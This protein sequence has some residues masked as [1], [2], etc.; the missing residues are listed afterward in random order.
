MRRKIDPRV[1]DTRRIKSSGN[2]F[3]DL[4]FDPA[5]AKVMALRAEVMIRMEQHLKAQGYTG[6]SRQTL[7]Y[8]PTARIAT[9]QGQV[10]GL[11]PRYAA[12]VGCAGRAEARA[13]VGRVRRPTK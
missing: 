8:N 1:S 11:Q 2:V 12:D 4:G 5:E 10:A 3:L 9:H 6:R 13:E 7:R